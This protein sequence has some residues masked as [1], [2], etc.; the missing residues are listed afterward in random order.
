LENSIIYYEYFEIKII[1]WAIEKV[2]EGQKWFA[3]LGLAALAL[4]PTA[5]K[6]NCC[7]TIKT[8]KTF[9]ETSMLDR[10]LDAFDCIMYMLSN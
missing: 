1:A 5:K 2:L 6:D 10:K 4:T 7:R 8:Y 3:G 9:E